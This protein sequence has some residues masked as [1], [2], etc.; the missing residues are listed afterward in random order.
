M[1]P[2]RSFAASLLIIILAGIPAPAAQ[3]KESRPSTSPTDVI[4]VLVQIVKDKAEDDALRNAAAQGLIV[5]GKESVPAILEMLEGKDHG[6]RLTAAAILTN[7]RPGQARDAIPALLGVIKDSH[8][9]KDLRRQA[10]LA[11]SQALATTP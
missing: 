10:A 2:S 5:I 6:L 4:P 7:M 8:E 3:D 9:D 11:L 1:K